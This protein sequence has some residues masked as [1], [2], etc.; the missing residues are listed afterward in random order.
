M[1]RGGRRERLLEPLEWLAAAGVISI[2]DLTCD[3]RA[4]LA[5]YNDEDGSYFK[6]Y[7]ADTG[8]MFHK[9]GI[10]PVVFL[11]DGRRAILAS[12]FRGAASRELRHAGAAGKRT[13]DVL[14]DAKR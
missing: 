4:P 10:D 5:P 3:D 7:V 13:E 14:L 6:V 12:D 2:N 1:I 11:D 8:I 9:F